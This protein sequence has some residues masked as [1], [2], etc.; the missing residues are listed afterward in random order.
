MHA[1][2][3]V[4]VGQGQQGFLH[5]GVGGLSLGQDRPRD[6][7]P[8]EVLRGSVGPPGAEQR[9]V[10]EGSLQANP[11]QGALRRPELGGLEQQRAEHQVRLVADRERGQVDAV[12]ASGPVQVLEGLALAAVLEERDSQVVRR[13]SRQLLRILDAAQHL[14]GIR[15]PAE[16]Q[17]DVRAQERDVVL[18]GFGDFALDPLQRLQGILGA[19]LLKMDSR[20]PEGGLVA[21]RLRDVAL[22]H[23]PDRPPGAVVHP[24]GELEVADGELRVADQGVERVE[25]GLVDGVVLADLG[26]QPLQRFEV[27]LLVRVVERL[28]EV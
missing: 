4:R 15:R 26:I 24:V 16:R 12:D 11:V 9:L 13:E 19:S 6:Q 18:D 8:L 3:A 14:D 21:H 1:Q 22:E 7:R 17:V 10:G 2:P 28:C 25:L 5:G 23:A 27:L 20:Q